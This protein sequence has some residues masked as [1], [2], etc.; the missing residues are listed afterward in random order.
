MRGSS[1]RPEARVLQPVEQPVPQSVLL[2]LL[3]GGRVTSGA[4]IRA[5]RSD[6]WWGRTRSARCGARRRAIVVRPMGGQIG[7]RRGAVALEPCRF[8]SPAAMRRAMTISKARSPRRSGGGFGC[9]GASSAGRRGGSSASRVPPAARSSVPR[10]ASASARARRAQS[11]VGTTRAQSAAGRVCAK[12]CA[13]CRVV[14]PRSSG[15]SAANR[16]PF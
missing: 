10:I 14:A 6:R 11:R 16:E 15:R 2:H 9:S 8:Q 13:R 1:G 4:C 12:R 7:D 5:A 3:P